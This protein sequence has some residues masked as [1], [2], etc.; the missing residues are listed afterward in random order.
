M[1]SQCLETYLPE[2]SRPRSRSVCVTATIQDKRSKIHESIRK[3]VLTD[4]VL[5]DYLIQQK[6]EEE[7]QEPSSRTKPLH[8]VDHQ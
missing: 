6:P 7:E 5:R 4:D 3:T 2:G 1:H 8:G